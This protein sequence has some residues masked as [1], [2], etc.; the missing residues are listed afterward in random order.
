MTHQELK[1]KVKLLPFA[2]GIY[3]MKDK[4][5]NII[6]VGKSKCLHNR[7]AHYFQPI[8]NL[9]PK[10]AKLSANIYDFEC[11]YTSSEAEALI[12]EN[13]LIKRHSPKY[14]IKL[15]DS[16]AYPYIKISYD[17]PYPR[18]S[19][20]RTRKGDNASYFG[21]YISSKNA[22]EIIDTVC[23]T[24]KIDTCNKDFKYNK[25]ICRPCLFYHLGQCMGPCTGNIP[26]EEY[27]DIFLEIESF[28]KGNYSEVIRALEEKMNSFAE[29]ME[30]E[31]AAKY[32]DRINSL[33]KLREHQN[34][35][36]DPD[37][38]FDVFGVYNSEASSALS[39]IFI[40][41]GK[42]I[43]K[44]DFV[45]SSFELCNEYEICDFIE[46]FY[47]NCGH[48]P[49][50]ILLSFKISDEDIT[51]LS[52][53]LSQAA[54]AKIKISVP[55][56]GEKK[57]YA[58]MA[59]R[60][61]REAVRQK[62]EMA[63][64]DEET[65]VKL[66]SLLGLDVVPERIEAYDISNNGKDDMYAGM[67]VIENARFKKSDYRLFQI[68]ELK[69]KTDDY[70]AMSEALRRR[71]SYLCNQE[72]ANSSFMVRPDLILLDGGTGHVN[73]ILN[74]MTELGLNIPVIGMVKDDF[75]KTRTLT[76][77]EQEISIAKEMSVFT[78]IYS[79]QE[80]VHR[81]TFSKMDASR[82]KKINNSILENI[83]GIGSAKAKAL[84]KK[85]KSINNIKNATIDELITV[86]GISESLAN[87]I[88]KYLKENWRTKE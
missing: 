60:N 62:I 82:T 50:N 18:I 22:N 24:Y 33:K 61:A 47:K 13:E 30:F 63:K 20:S 38:E 66:A 85:F 46:R 6:Y 71:L 7:V 69:D 26:P 8:Y 64:K 44:E 70:L 10:T 35:I 11:I 56:R 68:K 75:H 40:R 76:N 86:P 27:K 16:K 52:E 81:F 49:Q 2:P 21:P 34:I 67:V 37:K 1:E 72:K 65:L 73:T 53:R 48:I 43:D 45:F 19:L 3:M 57:I 58:D 28:L 55:E 54:G 42:V 12:L 80:E 5:G 79:I 23:K 36:T 78:F 4:N 88:L 84:I 39:L 87:K 25:R 32:R 29:K 41:N 74:V 14:N 17:S 77:G 31:N 51:E 83:E 59:C 9:E 15:K